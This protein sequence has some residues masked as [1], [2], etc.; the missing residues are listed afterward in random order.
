MFN[1]PPLLVGMMVISWLEWFAR[2][3]CFHSFTAFRE[4]YF[5][6]KGIKGY[7]F[8]AGKSVLY[9]YL[10]GRDAAIDFAL[11]QLCTEQNDIDIQKIIRRNTVFPALSSF[12]SS[13]QMRQFSSISNPLIAADR[14]TIMKEYAQFCRFQGLDNILS[15]KSD[16]LYR[17]MIQS[18]T[19]VRYCPDC[20][21][22]DNEKHGFPY[23]RIWHNFP[24]VGKCAVHNKDLL[25]FPD[26]KPD[27]NG[28]YT[29]A[30]PCTPPENLKYSQFVYDLFH[31]LYE[32]NCSI[33]L[34]S[35]TYAIYSVQ[36]KLR[37][38]SWR[39]LTSIKNE[40]YIDSFFSGLAVRSSSDLYTDQYYQ[41]ETLNYYMYEPQNL[42]CVLVHLF[43]SFKNFEPFLRN[44]D[45]E[46][47]DDFVK[48]YNNRHSSD[49]VPSKLK[50]MTT[51]E[52]NTVITDKTGGN[53]NIT[54]IDGYEGVCYLR[55][56]EIPSCDQFKTLMARKPTSGIVKICIEDIV[57]DLSQIHTYMFLPVKE[58]SLKYSPSAEKDRQMASFKTLC[59][60]LL[61]RFIVSGAEKADIRPILL[62]LPRNSYGLLSKK[63]C[64]DILLKASD[65]FPEIEFKTG[66]S[67]VLFR[68]NGKVV[69]SA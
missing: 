62:K 67:T 19:A 25:I 31:F 33:D 15:T 55:Y 51:E 68:K 49:L 37:L 28:V 40:G 7:Q 24:Y 41:D 29:T 65:D 18:S 53:C 44:K 14:D 3:N 35:F 13:V 9:P 8:S 50:N 57:S 46:P 23:A 42:I 52:L 48:D 12:Y 47:G 58:S 22:E 32:N 61:K 38:S 1:I 54:H 64:A 45:Y 21:E 5:A 60:S 6:A 69:R 2:A 20:I 16:F 4:S 66:S 10:F 36:N 30:S 63:E 39:L 56:N 17:M 34:T 27:L 59:D 43:G 26:G 11:S